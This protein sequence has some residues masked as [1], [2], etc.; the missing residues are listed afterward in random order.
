MSI[1]ITPDNELKNDELNTT[2]SF[3]VNKLISEVISKEFKS[4]LLIELYINEDNKKKLDNYLMYCIVIKKKMKE[5]LR[6]LYRK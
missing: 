3:Y 4:D 6:Y 1:K 2:V 5:K